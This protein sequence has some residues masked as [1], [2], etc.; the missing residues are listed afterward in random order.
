M[1]WRKKSKLEDRYG[2]KDISSRAVKKSIPKASIQYQNI[3]KI[4]DVHGFKDITSVYTEDLQKRFNGHPRYLILH[5]RPWDKFIQYCVI[6]VYKLLSIRE[7]DFS[8]F[9]SSEGKIYLLDFINNNKLVV[10]ERNVFEIK[11]FCEKNELWDKLI[12]LEF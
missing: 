6:D 8:A 9:T 5:N 1:N 11:S 7:S 3:V 12:C 4:I 2:T 10:S